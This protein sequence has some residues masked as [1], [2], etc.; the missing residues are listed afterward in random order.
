MKR[1]EIFAAILLL[2]LIFCAT[3]FAADDEKYVVL[4]VESEGATRSEA[5]EA[6]W[7]E[8]IR[9]AVGSYIDAK[10]ELNNDQLTER[11]IA[12]N[13][14]LVERSEIIG[15]DD[16]KAAQGV[17]K[18]KQRLWILR[19][20]LRDG[21]K[22]VTAGSAEISFSPEDVKRRREELNL[23]DLETKNASQE[24]SKAK[25]QTGAELLSAMLNRYK[26]EN[27]L[28]CYI[29][30]KPE[31]VKD[32]PDMFTLKVEISFNAKLYKES[33]VP[34]LEQ[35]LDQISAVKKNGLLIK[36]KNELRNIA[37]NKPVST[38]DT[39]ILQADGLGGEYNIAVYDKPERFGVRLYGFRDED[40]EKISGALSEF[41][42]RESM[43]AG[44]LIELQDENKE[45]LETVRENFRL[46][47]L[48]SGSKDSWAVH[49]SIIY[50]GNE[51]TRFSVPVSL[52]MPEE[53]L[54]YI[55][56]FRASLILKEAA[57][58]DLDITLKDDPSGGAVVEFVAK[59]S[60]AEKA[61]LK[62][63]DVI[64]YV[65]GKPV[66]N[67]KAAWEIIDS[68]EGSAIYFYRKSKG[69]ISI[70]IGK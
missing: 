7:L 31:P 32:K 44:I 24:T 14:G 12:Y 36:K 13:R 28:T 10:Q 57:N 64:T 60:K 58:I 61:G 68:F 4:D 21:A 47:Y 16:S 38:E 50:D 41:R 8:G 27:F 46:K 51:L 39:L 52:E 9:T 54:P 25:S 26:P 49:P 34:D 15:V 63:G 22:H 33:F 42:K 69:S 55:K 67:A 18:V 59:G 37:A 43:A 5:V 19:D 70:P 40:K 20:A 1:T 56:Y 11:I 65:D 48:L 6:G 53:V 45:T 29:P 2:V 23:K 62:A 17:Y 66:S 3:S 35:V 30:G